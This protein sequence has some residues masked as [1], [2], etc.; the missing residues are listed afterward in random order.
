MSRANLT[1]FIDFVRSEGAPVH[2]YPSL[3]RW[4]VDR[5]EEFWAAVWR[6]CGVVADERDDGGWWD[7]VLVGRDRVAP[8][9]PAL[10]P[11]WFSGAR[12]NFAENLLRHRDDREA[13]VSW[14]EDGRR[15]A[16]TYAEL[17]DAVARAA[18]ALRRDG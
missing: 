17:Y 14:G 16:Y 4:S 8:P 18:A 11:T 5:R 15:S 10:G 3:Y 6:F 2:D 1:R 12:L 13:L 9:D 7:T